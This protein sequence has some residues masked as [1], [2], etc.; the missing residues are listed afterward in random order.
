MNSINP[1]LNLF[2]LTMIVIS[3][4]IGIGIFRTP[5]V[6]A[7]S[8]ND[9]L[10]FILA[11]IVG[12]IISFI[13]ALVYAEL[14]SRF[15]KPG[16]YYKIVAEN[17]NPVL[18]FMLN[19]VA[20]FING[21]GAANVAIIGAEYFNPI[22]K[23]YIH[24]DVS[25]NYIAI[26]LITILMFLN[27]LGIK[28]G[29]R[30]QNILTIIKIFLILLIISSLFFVDKSN[31]FEIINKNNNNLI[32]FGIGL[33]SVFYTYGGY[34]AT[35]NFGGDIINSNKNLPKGI[36]FG[37]IIILSLY[38]LI[39]FTYIKILGI[40]GIKN[41]K[42]VAAS[43]AEVIFGWYGYYFV[44]ITIFLSALG[45]LN[46]NLM[47]TPRSYY[48][49]A[50]DKVLPK[51]FLNFNPKTQV[52]EFALF[53][54]WITIIISLIFL[55]TFEKILNYVMFTDSITIAVVASTIFILRNK[56]KNHEGYMMIGFPFLPILFIIILLSI[57]FFVLIS[58]TESALFGTAIFL[59]GY[60]VFK[61]MRYINK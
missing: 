39:N 45:F 2:D 38:L 29:A 12:G 49:M 40:E 44:S 35:M 15:Q 30:I 8:I 20:I 7:Q 21:A 33:I 1:K 18:A 6:I 10:F 31:N 48:A 42:L 46:V 24:Y 59:I 32:N 55:S 56:Q 60:P 36:L 4:V 23:Y 41:S 3:L 17:Y 25:S 14:G 28:T 26:I 13:G 53:F 9:P 47:Q 50:E 5:S 57:S 43:T 27:F 22:L 54:Y 58:S 19:W 16:G 11:W 61:I 37:S 51:I 52:Q 34:Q